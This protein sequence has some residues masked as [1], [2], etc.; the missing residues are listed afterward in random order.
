[1]QIE[2]KYNINDYVKIKPLEGY[3][4]RIAEIVVKENCYLYN[5][6]YFSNMEKYCYSFR[7]DEIECK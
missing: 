7:E 2:T 6:E 3:Q 4:G 1:M 5:V